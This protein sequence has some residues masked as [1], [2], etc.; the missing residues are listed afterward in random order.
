MKRFFDEHTSV[1]I[2]CIVISLL[3]CIVGNIKGVDEPGTSVNGSGLLKIVGDNLTDTID[4]YQK[5]VV[6]NEN[7][8]IQQQT[9][10]YQNC[11]VLE[12]G[13]LLDYSNYADT[14]FHKKLKQ[15]LKKGCIYSFSCNISGLKQNEEF[16]LGVLS[17]NEN[18]IF[19]QKD[20]TKSITFTLN[21][22]Y[23]EQT[24]IL[25]DDCKKPSSPIKITNIKLET[26]PKVTPY[27]E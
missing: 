9:L 26:G 13:F 22:K 25:I 7:L 20:G 6:P 24:T 14:Y 10:D 11:F 23:D 12:N 18:K 21:E 19:F 3:L 8:I 16:G 2:I 17:E 27:I 5:Q 4:T 15:P 1:V